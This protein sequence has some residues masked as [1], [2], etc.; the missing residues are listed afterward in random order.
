MIL[1]HGSA[2]SAAASPVAP[3][4]RTASVAGA[5]SGLAA[6][7]SAPEAGV[8]QQLEKL[9]WTELLKH[10]GLE[11]ALTQGAGESAPAFA[12]YAL[13]A[14]AEDLAERTPL[15]IAEQARPQGGDAVSEAQDASDE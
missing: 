13:E 3:P 10:S 4:A 1:F 2:A 12:R 11:S 7:A 15:G 6:A 9:L 5:A 14:I 8:G